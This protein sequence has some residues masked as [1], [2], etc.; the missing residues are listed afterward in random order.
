MAFAFS[1]SEWESDINEVFDNSSTAD[2]ISD[3]DGQSLIADFKLYK[4]TLI[5]QMRLRWEISS[6]ENYVK[7][8]MWRPGI[9]DKWN[10]I[11][12]DCSFKLMQLMIDESTRNILLV[13]KQVEIEKLALEEKREDKQ[14]NELNENVKKELIKI[15]QEIKI[16]KKRKFIRDTE[17]YKKGQIYALHDFQSSMSDSEQEFTESGQ[18]KK[19]SKNG[20]KDRHDGQNEKDGQIQLRDRSK[21]G[22]PSKR[23]YRKKT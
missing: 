6:L 2:S 9:L 17:D 4:K 1:D 10:N 7:S 3:L 23:R 18:K 12:S 11:L 22:Y 15:Q 16:R 21:W 5:Q 8:K 14:F 13:N 20:E 19:Q